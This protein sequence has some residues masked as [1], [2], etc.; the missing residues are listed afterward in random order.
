VL[1]RLAGDDAEDLAQET[2]LAAWRA[3]ASWR[4]EAS[5]RSWLLRIAWRKFLS[6]RRALKP[7]EPLEAAESLCVGPTAG[8]RAAID[9]AMQRLGERERMVLIAMTGFERPETLQKAREAG[10]DDY[11]AKPVSPDQLS[12]LIDIAWRSRRA[13]LSLGA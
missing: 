4:Q 2:F 6:N 3:A 13:R 8:E 5:Y 10:F 1:R 9:Q 11:V 7:T 12:R